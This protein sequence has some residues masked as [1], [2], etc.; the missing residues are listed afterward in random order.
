MKKG[1]N[2]AGVKGNVEN[3]QGPPSLLKDSRG[4]G[5][6]ETGVRREVRICGTKGVYYSKR[7]AASSRCCRREIEMLTMTLEK[8]ERTTCLAEYFG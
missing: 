8:Y 1:R 4:K 5:K 3:N 7:K 2:S 6:E